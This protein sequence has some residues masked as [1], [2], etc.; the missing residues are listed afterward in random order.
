M[1]NEGHITDEVYNGL[2]FFPK[3]RDAYGNEVERNATIS[4][5]SYQRAKTITHPSQHKQRI[6]RIERILADKNRVIQDARQREVAVVQN[7]KRIRDELI[8]ILCRNNSH[9]VND[10][11]NCEFEHFLKPHLRAPDVFEFLVAHHPTIT[12]KQLKDEKWKVGHLKKDIVAMKEALENNTPC[13]EL[14][15]TTL[16]AYRCR[17]Q[18]CKLNLSDCVDSSAQ[19]VVVNDDSAVET[20]IVELVLP[21]DEYEGVLPSELLA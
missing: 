4:Q 19:E 18:P 12:R 17:D 15:F 14:K 1:V 9:D 21:S 10:L 16:A 8:N 6:E 2:E 20:R 11:G 13:E 5:E 3:D 7:V